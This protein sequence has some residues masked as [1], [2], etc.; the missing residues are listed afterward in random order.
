MLVD[1]SSWGT[2]PG[3]LTVFHPVSHP[4]L[5][6]SHTVIVAGYILQKASAIARAIQSLDVMFEGVGQ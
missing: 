5:P 6:G 2:V 1:S 3:S 4:P